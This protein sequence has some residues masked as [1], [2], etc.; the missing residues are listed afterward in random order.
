[1]KR[2]QPSGAVPTGTETKRARHI[3]VL[4]SEVIESC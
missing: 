2:V 3:P 1:M 4:L